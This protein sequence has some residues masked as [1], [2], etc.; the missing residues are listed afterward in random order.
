MLSVNIQPGGFIRLHIKSH[1]AAR[2]KGQPLFLLQHVWLF[3]EPQLSS[4]LQGII[5]KKKS[6]SYFWTK[7]KKPE[8]PINHTMGIPHRQ[9]KSPYFFFSLEQQNCSLGFVLPWRKCTDKKNS[10]FGLSQQIHIL[11]YKLNMTPG[12]MAVTK[13]KWLWSC[14]PLKGVFANLKAHLDTF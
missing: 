4:D 3:W 9:L 5:D 10:Y 8:G 12:A 2:R 6:Y 11:S 14:F 1:L 7:I 13:T